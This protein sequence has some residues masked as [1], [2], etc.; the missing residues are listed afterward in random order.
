MES[1]F[2]IRCERSNYFELL[3]FKR[4]I[5]FLRILCAYFISI[6]QFLVM[7]FISKNI[8]QI[9]NMLL[10][11]LGSFLQRYDL[12]TRLNSIIHKCSFE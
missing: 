6:L 7:P 2:S 1:L 11:H 12:R 5:F 9:N 8:D 3:P 10:T 4:I